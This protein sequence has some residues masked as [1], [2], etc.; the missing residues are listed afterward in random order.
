MGAG[1]SNNQ[2]TL[3]LWKHKNLIFA[4]S[5]PVMVITGWLIHHLSPENNGHGSLTTCRWLMIQRIVSNRRQGTWTIWKGTAKE[6]ISTPECLSVLNRKLGASIEVPFFI[7][8]GQRRGEIAKQ[9][10]GGTGSNQYGSV[11]ERN[12]CKTLSDIGISRKE[13]S[14]LYLHTKLYAD[15]TC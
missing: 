13:S 8:E 14:T 4:S 9:D 2:L 7:Q 15:T 6:G 10:T 11:P 12:T 1:T 5:L 3:G